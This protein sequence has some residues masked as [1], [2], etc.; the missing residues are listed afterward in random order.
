MAA[1]FSLEEAL[2]QGTGQ[3]TE[4]SLEEAL[5]KAPAPPVKEAGFSLGDIAKSFGIGAAGS[6][7]ALTDVAGAENLLSSKLGKGVEGLQQS[8]NPE[9][10]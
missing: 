5:G 10:R 4:F 8:L 9:R 3:P 1:E 6:T 7:K 2:G